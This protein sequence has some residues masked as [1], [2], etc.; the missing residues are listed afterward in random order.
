[1]SA[2]PGTV[3][4]MLIFNALAPAATIAVQSHWWGNLADWGNL[5]S[6][7]AGVTGVLLLA[8]AIVGGSLGLGDW[9]AKQREQ[10][11][12]ARE[13]AESIR[14]ERYRVLHGWTSNGVA[15]YGVALVTTAAEMAT[16]QEQL[17]AREPS[18]YVILRVNESANGNA[19]RAHSLRQLIATEGYVARAPTMGEYEALE[20]GRRLLLDID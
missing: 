1:M 2:I 15:V 6:F 14:L 20:K 4:R 16:A 13:Q 17:T 7:L 5:G 11:A 12:L 10:K 8:A 3:S 18:D 9:R 19:N